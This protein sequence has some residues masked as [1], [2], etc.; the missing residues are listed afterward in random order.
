MTMRIEGMLCTPHAESEC[1]ARS[2]SPD[3][4][5]SMVTTALDGQVRTEIQTDRL[6]SLVASVDDYLMNLGIAEEICGYISLANVELIANNENTADN[7]KIIDAAFTATSARD[8]SDNHRK[9][10]RMQGCASDD[11]NN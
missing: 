1:V 11:N 3:N 5:S 8:V 2:L 10:K 4:L 7:A 9:R 6:R